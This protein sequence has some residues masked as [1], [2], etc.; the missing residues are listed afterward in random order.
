MRFRQTLFC[1][2]LFAAGAVSGGYFFSGA[3]PRSFLAFD[4]CKE[5]C[6]KA[7]E[8]AGL[9]ASAGIHRTPF[10]VPDVAVESDTCVAINYPRP[11]DRVHYVLF[12]KRDV[13][14]IASLTPADLPYVAGCFAL[15]RQLVERDKLRSYRVLTNGPGM[16]D[17]AY[18]HFHLF[19][20]DSGSP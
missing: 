12:P 8:L 19:A 9:I 14:D 10:F 16:Q 1:I 13:R 18:L 4:D 7:N 15:V 5:R 17:I 6:L 20:I 3:T 11:T 2:A